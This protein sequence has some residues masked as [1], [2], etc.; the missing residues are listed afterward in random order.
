ML[1]CTRISSVVGMVLLVSAAVAQDGKVPPGV[2]ARLRAV[3][4]FVDV[5]RPVWVEFSLI[6]NTDAPVTLS[7]PGAV[8]ASSDKTVGLPLGHVFSGSSPHGGVSIV[9]LMD[10]SLRGMLMGFVSDEKTPKV[11]LGPR[12][13]VGVVVDLVKHYPTV[14]RVP[15]RYRLTWQPYDGRLISNQVYID[16]APLQQAEIITDVGNMTVV[17][18]YDDAPL[19]VANFIELARENF[20]NSTPLFIQPGHFVLCGDPVG[21]GTGIRKDGKKLP[22]EFNGRPHQKGSLSMALLDDDPYSAS[23]QFFIC[24]TRH[25]D[26]D[27]KYTVFGQVVGEESLLTLDKI[28]S[29]PLGPDGRPTEDTRI[30]S[31]RI[32]NLKAENANFAA[33]LKAT[34][35]SQVSK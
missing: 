16:I 10:N 26:W 12:A 23:C 27:E 32:S 14:L 4:R 13:S 21:D 15:G 9:N 24:N 31:I 20:Y 1:R 6:N 35:D 17:F 3:S 30:R 18:Y 19:T 8:P 34:N 33:A 7:V 28:M 5:G 29:L 22:P 25:A 11:I 2:E